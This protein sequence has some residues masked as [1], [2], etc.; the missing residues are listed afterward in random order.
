MLAV[1]LSV[2]SSMLEEINDTTINMYISFSVNIFKK[3]TAFPEGKFYRTRA[4]L[5][6]LVKKFCPWNLK[7]E[8]K[9]IAD[10]SL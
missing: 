4:I 3:I 5:E 7:K 1:S 6:I 8:P 9:F 10:I 2:T